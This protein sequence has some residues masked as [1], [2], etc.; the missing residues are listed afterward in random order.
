LLEEWWWS[1]LLFLGDEANVS[2]FWIC[3]DELRSFYDLYTC[4]NFS[5][6]QLF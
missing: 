6:R 4:I 1:M 2:I 5:V 3:C